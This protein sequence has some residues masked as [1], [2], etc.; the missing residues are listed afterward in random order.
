MPAAARNVTVMHVPAEPRD[1]A[2]TQH[3][4]DASGFIHYHQARPVRSPILRPIRK[5]GPQ[6][7]PKAGNFR[8]VGWHPARRPEQ[9]PGRAEQGSE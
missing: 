3:L 2:P 9:D 6:G 7:L 1:V 8:V 4:S 5:I